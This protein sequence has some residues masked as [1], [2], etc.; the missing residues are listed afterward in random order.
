MRKTDFCICENKDT[1]QLHDNR[2]ADQ[3]LCFRYK[4]STIPLLP[5]CKISSLWPSSLT[6]QP[7]LCQN[8][9]ETPKTRLKYSHHLLYLRYEPLCVLSWF[10]TSCWCR[11]LLLLGTIL[12]THTVRYPRKPS[13]QSSIAGRYFFHLFS[14]DFDV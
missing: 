7:G 8:W 2:E 6:V 3:R 10:P 11:L 12:G 13:F 4:D 14:N 9:S 5:K 1:D